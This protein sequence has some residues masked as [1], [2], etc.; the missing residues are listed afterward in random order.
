MKE[1]DNLKIEIN[2]ND[3]L[4]KNRK[5]KKSKVINRIKLLNQE[6]KMQRI[7]FS[8]VRKLVF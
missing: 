3:Q 1:K 2:L 6:F 7:S 4:P 5:Q 8:T